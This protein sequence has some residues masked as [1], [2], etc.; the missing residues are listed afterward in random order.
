MSMDLNVLPECYVDNE[1]NLRL[2]TIPL[3]SA[4]RFGNTKQEQ[5]LKQLIHKY[6]SQS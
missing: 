5:T 1:C 4:R 2:H 3:T 6:L